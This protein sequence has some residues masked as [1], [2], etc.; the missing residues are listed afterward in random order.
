MKELVREITYNGTVEHFRAQMQRLQRLYLPDGWLASTGERLSFWEE[1]QTRRKPIGVGTSSMRMWPGQPRTET[2]Y[3]E[4]DVTP[5]TRCSWQV[6]PLEKEAPGCAGIEAYEQ[7]NSTTLLHFLDG[8]HPYWP[9]R[10][11]RPIGVAFV[12]FCEVVINE[13]C[14][15]VGEGDTREPGGGQFP[16]TDLERRILE[17]YAIISECQDIIQ[18]SDSPTEKRRNR[19]IIKEQWA[20]IRGWLKDYLAMTLP[21]AI[22]EIA[23]HFL[24]EQTQDAP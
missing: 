4:V 11:V 20:L 7:P 10:E 14:Q 13:V 15:A 1:R 17:S 5:S 24:S 21:S 2:I 12:E 19:R 3:G 8:Y 9:I 18:A 6:E 16:R 22:A 23:A